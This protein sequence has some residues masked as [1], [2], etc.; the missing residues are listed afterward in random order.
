MKILET[1]LGFYLGHN[2]MDGG[3]KCH[4]VVPRD[5]LLDLIMAFSTEINLYDVK[6]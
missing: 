1:E 3:T 5:H 6:T 2:A 4:Q